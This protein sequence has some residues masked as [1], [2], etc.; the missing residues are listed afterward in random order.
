[1]G[2][3]GRKEELLQAAVTLF[4]Q[5]GYHATTV[6][7]I[8][9][10]CGMQSGSIYAHI[11]SKEDL[12]FQIVIEVA[13]RFMEQVGPIARGEGRAAVKLGR[14]MAAHI[15]VVTD[16]LETATIFLHEWRALSP[17]RRE[18]VAARRTAYEELF[19]AII[20]EGVASGE[21]A[22]SVDERF[23][24]LLVLSAANWVYQWYRPQ[25]GLDPT[26]VAERFAELILGGIERRGGEE[27]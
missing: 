19:A 8:A 12:L 10:A 7:E 25:G 17:D 4:S 27:R 13:D 23:A 6:R 16:S 26:A 21:F 11:A 2:R 24:R 20:R 15:A 18:A 1:M 3:P 5:K 14:A 9:E 22:P